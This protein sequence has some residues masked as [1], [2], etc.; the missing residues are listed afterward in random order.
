VIPLRGGVKGEVVSERRSLFSPSK[1]KAA[2][3]LGSDLENPSHCEKNSIIL[4][5]LM[6]VPV[7]LQAQC[8]AVHPIIY[9]PNP[10]QYCVLGPKFIESKIQKA[11]F[12][13]KSIIY[14]LYFD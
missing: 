1:Q 14:L 3:K 4:V 13:S 9:L 11:L 8:R 6:D 10:F 5:N 2:L 12:L 7:F